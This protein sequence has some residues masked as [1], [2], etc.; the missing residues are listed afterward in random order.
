MIIWL[1]RDAS[2]RQVETAV[3]RG[4][5]TVCEVSRACGAGSDCGACQHRLAA[6]IEDARS[7]V[8]ASG[9]MP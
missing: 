9:E 6:L 1:C 4:A 8:C 3:A 2:E 5:T 7:V